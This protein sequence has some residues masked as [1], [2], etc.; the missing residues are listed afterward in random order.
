MRM[1]YATPGDL[2]LMLS[3]VCY[4]QGTWARL[5]GKRLTLLKKGKTMA[6]ELWKGI[7][8]QKRGYQED[9]Q[10]VTVESGEE[11]EIKIKMK[12]TVEL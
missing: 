8:A 9:K 12:K 10:T 4:G 1:G 11:V 2:V 7:T 5:Y 6:G 3:Q